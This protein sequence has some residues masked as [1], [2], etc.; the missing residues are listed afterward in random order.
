[1][2]TLLVSLLA[3]QLADISA[4]PVHDARNIRVSPALRRLSVCFS[5]T[6]ELRGPGLPH[7]RGSEV[8]PAIAAS[9]IVDFTVI[10]QLTDGRTDDQK[11]LSLRR[12]LLA[13]A[14]KTTKVNVTNGAC[15][16]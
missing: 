14:L 11:T 16:Q 10:R 9:A 1:M 6:R 5:S 15:K 7:R 8:E 3:D 12:I 4:A 13:E 2:F